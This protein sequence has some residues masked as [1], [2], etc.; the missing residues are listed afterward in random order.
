MRYWKRLS[1]TAKTRDGQRT[2]SLL[3]AQACLDAKQ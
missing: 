3:Q 2:T 1:R